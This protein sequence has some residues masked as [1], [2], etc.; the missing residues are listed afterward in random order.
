M[1]YHPLNGSSTT[2]LNSGRPVSFLY[3]VPTT[4]G[5][6]KNGSLD[7]KAGN[8]LIRRRGIDALTTL[9]FIPALWNIWRGT[10]GSAPSL[11]QPQPAPMPPLPILLKK[12]EVVSRACTPRT[13][14]P[15]TRRRAACRSPGT[16]EPSR[17]RTAQPRRSLAFR[18]SASTFS[19]HVR[20]QVYALSRHGSPQAYS[21]LPDLSWN[22]L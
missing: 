16:H 8:E 9:R 10:D 13:S 15:F 1:A 19:H 17:C 6:R 22:R 5:H 21:F 4:D 3:E 7:P 2:P 11:L 20:S 14:I 12:G 18:P